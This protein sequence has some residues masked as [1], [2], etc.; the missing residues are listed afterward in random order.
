MDDLSDPID[1]LAV[2]F[3]GRSRKQHSFAAGDCAGC[4]GTPV[5]NPA[6]DIGAVTKSNHEE[7]REL[8]IDNS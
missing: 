5:N 2:G 1:S 6:A 7:P 8:M 4:F 3:C